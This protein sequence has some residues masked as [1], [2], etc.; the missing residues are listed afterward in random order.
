MVISKQIT[1]WTRNSKLVFS[2]WTVNLSTKDVFKLGNDSVICST[3][4]YNR[5]FKA[6]FSTYVFYLCGSWFRRQEL[7]S[8]VF[9]DCIRIYCTFS[10][11]CGW[12]WPSKTILL[13]LIVTFRHT[14][15]SSVVSL[16]PAH[17]S[18]TVHLL[19]WPLHLDYCLQEVESCSY[20]GCSWSLW[21]KRSSCLGLPR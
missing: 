21:Y 5:N 8:E 18:H 16:T 15:I 12:L 4:I 13:L 17:L 14:Q 9:I 19:F 6:F 7:H 11:I 10:D 20:L 1:C 3:Q 2:F